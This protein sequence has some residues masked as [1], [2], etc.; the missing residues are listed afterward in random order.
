MCSTEYIKDGN[1]TIAGLLELEREM[2]FPPV[3][4]AAEVLIL[5]SEPHP[6]K[7]ATITHFLEKCF[8]CPILRNTPGKSSLR[9]RG[10]TIPQEP[11][12][13]SP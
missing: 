7:K 12:E 9:M 13:S 5:Q 4:A 8:V 3:H 1:S 10:I 11:M 6:Q 2:S